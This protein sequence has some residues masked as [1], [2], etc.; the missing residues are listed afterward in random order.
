MKKLSDVKHPTRKRVWWLLFLIPI[1]YVIVNNEIFPISGSEILKREVY[2]EV[3]PIP[4]TSVSGDE[5]H[6]Q[7]NASDIPE[8]WKTFDMIMIRFERHWPLIMSVMAFFFRRKLVGD[9]K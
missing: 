1:I 5:V 6:G 2:E 7:V 9:P 4:E 3:S 8:G